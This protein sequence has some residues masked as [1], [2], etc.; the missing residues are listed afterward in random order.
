MAIGSTMFDKYIPKEHTCIWQKT[1]DLRWDEGM[2]TWCGADFI[3]TSN[4]PQVLQQK[5]ICTV[6]GK[7][8][9]EEV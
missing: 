3:K 1:M 6:C 5:S 9:W 8:K 2:K 7:E 4:G